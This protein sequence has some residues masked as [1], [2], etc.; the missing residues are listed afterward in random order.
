MTREGT[1]PP[2]SKLTLSLHLGDDFSARNVGVPPR[3]RNLRCASFQSVQTTLQTLRVLW[4]Y[5]RN[6]RKKSMRRLQKYMVI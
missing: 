2:L 1:V 4:I 3:T 6:Y 5:H